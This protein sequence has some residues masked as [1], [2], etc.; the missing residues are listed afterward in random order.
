MKKRILIA[1]H[2][3]GKIKEFTELL[4]GYSAELLSLKSVGV[5]T[6]FVET[7]ATFK[8]NALAKARYYS[9]LSKLPTVAEDSGLC[10]D[11]LGGD[12]R[13]YSARWGG[14]E[15]SDEWRR[16]QLLRLMSHLE[17]DDDRT[18]HFECVIA[19]VVPSWAEKTYE[20]YAYGNIA[21]QEQGENGFGYDSIFCPTMSKKTFAE[22]STQEKNVMSHRGRAGIKFYRDLP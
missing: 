15:K 12:P 2:N 4:S 16:K 21:Y 19:L 1:T 17:Y 20:G 6:T 18:A 11:V 5:T 9:H 7:G 22:Y 10:V 8:E 3:K 14:E 13:V